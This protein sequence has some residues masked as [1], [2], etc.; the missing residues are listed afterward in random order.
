MEGHFGFSHDR[1]GGDLRGPLF[2]PVA[3]NA[4]KAGYELGVLFFSER[5]STPKT[6]PSRS[7]YGCSVFDKLGRIDAKRFS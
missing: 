5:N 1:V 7:T 2:C 6:L 3:K 4:T